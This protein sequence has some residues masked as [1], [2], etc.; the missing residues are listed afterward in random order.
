M[1]IDLTFHDYKHSHG[2]IQNLNQQTEQ[3]KTFYY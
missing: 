1:I 2:L 3:V